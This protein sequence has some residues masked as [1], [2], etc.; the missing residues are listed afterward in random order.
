[1]TIACD[2][3]MRDDGRLGT[4]ERLIG[5]MLNQLEQALNSSNAMLG[6]C[7]D[8]ATVMARDRSVERK[9]GMP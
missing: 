3:K 8:R 2:A 1:M 6:K 4:D 7:A 9:L 5:L